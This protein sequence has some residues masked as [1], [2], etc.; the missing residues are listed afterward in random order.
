MCSSCYMASPQA[1]AYTAMSS[2]KRVG[3]DGDL[4]QP[5]LLHRPVAPHACNV[6]QYV[7]VTEVALETQLE[8]A[9]I[10]TV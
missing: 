6:W 8:L 10:C 1:A 7:T 2:R 3:M 9:P 4:V 5:D